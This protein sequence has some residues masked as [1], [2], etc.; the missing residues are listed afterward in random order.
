[1]RSVQKYP[2][3]NE[4]CLKF[5]VKH[6]NRK[7]RE[8]EKKISLFLWRKHFLRLFAKMFSFARKGGGNELEVA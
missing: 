2:K 7:L 5:E 6:S 4:K 8:T 1:M 3:L